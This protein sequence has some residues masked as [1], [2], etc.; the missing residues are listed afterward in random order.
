MS[1][2]AFLSLGFLIGNLLGL[3]SNGVVKAIMP[4]L[5][6]FGGGSAVGFLHK[7]EDRYRIIAYQLIFVFS[8]S[9]LIGTYTGIIVSE[10][11][12]LSPERGQISRANSTIKDNKYLFSKEA[13]SKADTIDQLY[14]SELMKAE[15]AYQG[16]Y[17]IITQLDKKNEK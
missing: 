2:L 5:F 11:Q 16:L 3:S 9:C 7:I 14:A 8:I 13:I 10:H 4:L 17:E 15:D 12:L 6:A 1:I